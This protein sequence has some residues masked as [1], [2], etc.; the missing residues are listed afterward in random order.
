MKRRKIDDKTIDKLLYAFGIGC[1]NIEACAYAEIGD[2]TLYAL[3]K[4]NP[5]LKDRIERAKHKQVLKALTAS[6]KLLE[7]GDAVHIRWYLERRKREDYTL[8]HDININASGSLSIEDRKQALHDMLSSF[9]R[10]DTPSG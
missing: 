2:S 10:S 1:N 5:D 6:D 7:D 4:D 8:S 9:K 3:I